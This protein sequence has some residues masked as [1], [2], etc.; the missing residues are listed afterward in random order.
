MDPASAKRTQRA[1]RRA[2]PRRRSRR[3]R[4]RRER[5]RRP[6]RPGRA[7]APR[8]DVEGE[9]LVPRRSSTAPKSRPTKPLPTIST[10]PRGTAVAP[11]RTHAER[12]HHRRAPVRP[13]RRHVDPALRAHPLGEAAG[14]DG[15]CG[16]P[17]AGRFV[18]RQA[19]LA[20]PAGG[21]VDEGHALPVRRLG[22]D[23]VAEHGSCVGR[24]RASRRPSRR[25][26]R[27]GHGPGRPARRAPE[28]P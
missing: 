23:L 10:R 8:V 28:P 18:P 12:L 16:E 20:L 2:V 5:R 17:L 19:P 26:R 4:C 6:D 24:R 14:A 1:A 22:D 13:R 25:A 9:H 7:R 21:V 3:R 11:R 27:R 15:R